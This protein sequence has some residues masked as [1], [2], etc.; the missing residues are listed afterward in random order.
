MATQNPDKNA[1]E[2]SPS[3]YTRSKEILQSARKLFPEESGQN[4]G[5]FLLQQRKK[6]QEKSELARKSEFEKKGG[7]KTL[8]EDA[9]KQ[10]TPLEETSDDTGKAGRGVYQPARKRSFELAE[11]IFKDAK[12]PIDTEA[13]EILT[14]TTP[15]SSDYPTKSNFPVI[16]FSLAVIKDILDVPFDVS[17]VL[18]IVASIFSFLIGLV[19]FFWGFGKTNRLQRKLFKGFV[20]RWASM[21]VVEL[22]PG[23]QIIPATAIFVLLAHFRE[24]KFVETALKAIKLT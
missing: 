15:G 24:T 21:C 1:H 6:Q 3:R 8:I 9:S 12:M 19:I 5:G 2:R 13:L 11:K 23:L 10:E 14:K 22:I 18:V 4:T 17:V 20:K 16:I 7:E